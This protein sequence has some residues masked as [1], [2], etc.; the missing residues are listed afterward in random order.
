M[1]FYHDIVFGQVGQTAS[2]R[3]FSFCGSLFLDKYAIIFMPRHN[4]EGVLSK[5]LAGVLKSGD[6]EYK[7]NEIVYNGQYSIDNLEDERN[8]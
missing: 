6:N 1:N 2:R 3:N 8:A 5:I 7:P 4:E